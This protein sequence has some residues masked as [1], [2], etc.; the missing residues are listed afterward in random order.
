M[1]K[2]LN[3]PD[4]SAGK[5]S[6]IVAHPVYVWKGSLADTPEEG[7]PWLAAP[8][9]LL[10]I[11]KAT[12]L[13]S[14]CS[15]YISKARMTCCLSRLWRSCGAQHAVL[16][17]QAFHFEKIFII[18]RG[19]AGNKINCLNDR[20]ENGATEQALVCTCR[21][22]TLMYISINV[23]GADSQGLTLFSTTALV[24][25]NVAVIERLQNL[26]LLYPD[27]RH[28]PIVLFQGLHRH[29]L[30]SPVIVWVVKVQNDLSKVTL[31][32]E[33]F[34]VLIIRNIQDKKEP[35]IMR[36]E[37]S[38]SLINESLSGSVYG[39]CWGPCQGEFHREICQDL[40]P[41]KKKPHVHYIYWDRL[42]D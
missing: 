39:K 28:M 14:S 25:D 40:C 5:T 33:K 34:A 6:G 23:A 10:S 22:C 9:V 17:A 26:Y 13:L 2:Y 24:L 3:S 36:Y 20:S 37:D 38:P 18:Y 8:L 21:H 29:T 1:F 12:V 32:T 30:P 15:H 4:I 16:K 42:K 7:T 11:H 27:F 19:T 41:E 35:L 31:G